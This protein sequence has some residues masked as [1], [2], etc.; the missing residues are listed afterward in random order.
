MKYKFSPD[1]KTLYTRHEDGSISATPTDQISD[2]QKQLIY[3]EMEW[4]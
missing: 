2:E 4:Q 1:Y 3:Q